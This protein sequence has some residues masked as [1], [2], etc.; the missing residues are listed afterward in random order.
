ME[1][2]IAQ[3][4][5]RFVKF[6]N[7]EIQEEVE[8]VHSYIK[9]EQIN[10]ID[11]LKKEIKQRVYEAHAIAT[12]IYEDN[13][14]SKSKQEI[15][16][17]IKTALGSIIYNKG[18]GYFFIDNEEG[19]GILQ[20]LNRHLENVNKLEFTDAKGYQFVK[21]IVETIK[22]KSERYDSYYWYKGGDKINSYE[23]ISFYKYFEPL[24]FA[25]GTGEYVDDFLN[26]MKERILKNVSN[27]KLNNNSYIFIIDYKG[28]ILAH[29][30][31]DKIGKN[32]LNNQDKEGFYFIR[33]MLKIVS[34]D[35]KQGFLSYYYSTFEK[36]PFKKTTFVKSFEQWKWI[37]GTG[38]HDKDLNEIIKKETKRF[39]DKYEEEYAL[40]LTIGISSTF[41]FL[42]LSI[43]ISKLLEKRLTSYQEKIKMEEMEFKNLF[44]TS[45]VGL[46]MT[47]KEGNFVKINKKFILMLGFETKD[48]LLK[49][50]WE[51]IIDGK[52]TQEEKKSIK[53]LQ[54]GKV[55]NI[56]FERDFKRADKTTFDGYLNAT[57]FKVNKEFK[58]ILS[59]F[60]DISEVKQ[61]DNLLAQQSKMAAMGEML[62]N[63]AHQWRQPLSAITTASS[64]LK[65]QNAIGVINKN[66]LDT[67]LDFIKDTSLYLSSTIEDFRDFFNPENKESEDINIQDLV[68]Q[69][70]NLILAQL[71]NKEIEIIKDIDNIQINI[72]KNELIQ[73][74][75]NI[76]N[77]ARDALSE[78][79]NTRRLIFIKIKEKNRCLVISIKDNA[80]GIPKNI[81]DRIFEPYFTT[82]HK[83]QGT[84][85]GLYMA[86]E[87][88]KKHM[89]GKIKVK[90]QE[91]E[92]ENKKYKGAEFK[93]IIP[94]DN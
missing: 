84:G 59:S 83:S 32:H 48:E 76:L 16:E 4:S 70:L 67:S 12:R 47:D 26:E 55:E 56:N 35:M 62:A 43:L 9:N 74:L 53:L 45:D 88:V 89:N 11:E 15:Q 52:F 22:Q 87:I 5:K 6:H 23:K 60:I 61:K 27:T 2:N 39:K 65:V 81:I 68:T 73:I 78:R 33:E 38:Y 7:E 79:L 82:K 54:E 93:L 85:I 20:P 69:T 66:D 36:T 8:K 51:D 17:L 14:T 13:K 63:I 31:K 41:F 34:S 42:L 21:T 80:G 91:F 37:I 86:D 75:M 44:E 29:L 77:N 64:G 25:I 94:M 30:Q 46:A 28:N 19:I 10:S 49:K 92:F 50:S 40:I 24:N 1:E 18:R 90:N 58:Y 72:L 3:T 57:A 71:K